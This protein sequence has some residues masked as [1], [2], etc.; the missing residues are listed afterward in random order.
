MLGA[1]MG[2][3][4]AA[5]GPMPTDL[6]P[7]AVGRAGAGPVQGADACAWGGGTGATLT[8]D[9]QY[10]TI[11]AS[12]TRVPGSFT[13][14]VPDTARAVV[15]VG[16]EGTGATLA[17]RARLGAGCAAGLAGG[18]A[19][20]RA[21]WTAWTG[22]ETGMSAAPAAADQGVVPLLLRAASGTT[23][24]AWQTDTIRATVRAHT[25]LLVVVRVR[26]GRGV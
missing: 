12:G 1:L 21:E 4:L 20:S 22:T 8:L 26:Q 3:G 23:D 2:V 24:S 17:L 11:D 7:E 9:G 18:A 5:C 10:V 13:A 6:A 25:Q 15:R 16:G 19:V 14:T